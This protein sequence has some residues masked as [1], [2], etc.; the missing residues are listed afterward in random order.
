[1]NRSFAKESELEEDFVEIFFE[2][3]ALTPPKGEG[4]SSPVFGQIECIQVER[5]H[6]ANKKAR[7]H[8]RAL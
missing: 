1:M 7:S 8:E 3:P 5:P 6:R 2:T 4:E